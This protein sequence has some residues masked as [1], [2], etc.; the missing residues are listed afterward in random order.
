[1]IDD[2]LQALNLSQ[3][4]Q[5]KPN[6]ARPIDRFDLYHLGYCVFAD[7]SSIVVLSCF[8]LPLTASSQL[9]I[10]FFPYL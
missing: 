2:L 5:T 10:T 8:S 9:Y 7:I 4:T 6:E 3:V 1:M